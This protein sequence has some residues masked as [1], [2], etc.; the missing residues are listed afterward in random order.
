MRG[1]GECIGRSAVLQHGNPRL[2][3]E[4]FVP[5]QPGTERAVR[6]L[7]W[8]LRYYLRP[9]GRE[10]IRACGFAQTAS[11]GFVGVALKPE[12][13]AYYQ[14]LQTCGSVWECPPCQMTIK[15]R[16][17]EEVRSVVEQ[18]GHSRCAMLTLTVRHGAGDDLAALRKALANAWRGFTR[19][20]A[21]KGFCRRHRVVGYVRA[22]EVTHGEANGWHPH[23]HILL[24]FEGA[25]PERE[26]F[27]L[28][29]GLRWLPR[30]VGWLVDRW[31]SMVGRYV[32][33]KH[34]PDEDHGVTLTPCHAADYVSKLGLEI[35]DPGKK[36]GRGGGRTPLQLAAQFADVAQELRRLER[37]RRVDVRRVDELRRRKSRLSQL[38][39]GYCEA[40]RG[41]RQL[42]WS[43]RLKARFGI[44]DRTDLEVAQEEEPACDDQSV[45]VGTIPAE[46]WKTI[47][48]RRVGN[49]SAAYYCLRAAE[50][51][52]GPGLRKAVAAIIGGR[53]IVGA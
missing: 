19:G 17:A 21:W 32:G 48:A 14:G 42:T 33:A 9:V 18:H 2:G 45:V 8:R 46:T 51:G 4:D 37:R 38:W 13:K 29:V 20:N 43:R 44:Q 23:L 49:V 28:D 41:A 15:A 10:R 3:R 53:G 22:L 11:G 25:L 31:S 40:M 30:D 24:L 50:I 7:M 27:E 16:R 1:V 52:G 5:S 6:R 47:R 34:E 26:C 36:S 12:G 39:R 35:S